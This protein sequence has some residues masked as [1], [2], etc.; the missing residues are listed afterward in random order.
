MIQLEGRQDRMQHWRLAAPSEGGDQRGGARGERRCWRVQDEG[1][2][3]WRVESMEGPGWRVQVG[4]VSR[5][6]GPG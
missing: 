4:R 5:V 3:G 1:Y 6:E 2:L